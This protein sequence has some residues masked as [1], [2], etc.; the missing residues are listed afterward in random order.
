MSSDKKTVYVGCSVE[1]FT[2]YN[3]VY[4]KSVHIEYYKNRLA[5]GSPSEK[6]ICLY[7]NTNDNTSVKSA[8]AT[9]TAAQLVGT[10]FGVAD[11]ADGLF[12]VYVLCDVSGASLATADCGWDS[13]TTVGIIADWQKVYE[14]GMAN[15]MDVAGNNHL[16][17]IGDDF[18]DFVLKWE[19]LKLAMETCDYD[20]VDALWDGLFGDG[21][22]YHS[23][24][25]CGR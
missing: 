21:V 12:Y 7:E 3:S 5:S 1:N 15:I 23:P 13:M 16:C 8:F 4:I 9:L 14:Y 10:E 20:N 11:F 2:I 25:G 18:I 22:M 24:C 17:M 6:A 19:A